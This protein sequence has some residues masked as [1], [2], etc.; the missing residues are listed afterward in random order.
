MKIKRVFVIG[1]GLMGSG[2]A[3]VC[4]Q[5]DIQVCL[6]DIS[7]EALDKALKGISWSVGK[8]I[9]KGRLKEDLDAIMGRIRTS[10]ELGA[11]SEADLIIQPDVSS[12]GILEFAAYEPII[13]IGY[14]AAREE[15]S[16][17]SGVQ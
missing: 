17:W 15:L 2:I 7:Q 1:G 11:A 16:A 8:F 4:A 12:F 14:Q 6:Y 10:S 13:E 5:A 9:E 3:Q